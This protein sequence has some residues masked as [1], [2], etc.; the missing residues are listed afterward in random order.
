V[1]TQ[2]I[3]HTKKSLALDVISGLSYLH[4]SNIIHRDLK[5]SNILI[6]PDNKAC[7]TDFGVS[8]SI[9]TFS[10]NYSLSIVGTPTYLAPEICGLLRT[11]ITYTFKSDYYSLGIIIWEIFENNAL[12][13]FK[14]YPQ[15]YKEMSQLT[16]ASFIHH[17]KLRPVFEE[18][19]TPAFCELTQQILQLWAEDP[20]QRPNDLRTVAQIIDVIP[21]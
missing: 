9:N 16:I 17:H 6:T 5:T 20:D 14:E 1:I 12:P 13:Y 7:I 21:V 10:N 2:L 8:K 11:D 4:F 15:I 18:L 3:Y 19:N